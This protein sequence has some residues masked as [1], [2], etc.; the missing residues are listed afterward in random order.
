MS[1]SPKEVFALAVPIA[2]V[3]GVCYSYGYWGHFEIN[4]LQFVSLV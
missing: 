3:V 1:T 2:I 4:A